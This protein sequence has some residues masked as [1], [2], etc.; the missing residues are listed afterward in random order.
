NR[1]PLVPGSDF[2]RIATGAPRGL[3]NGQHLFMPRVSA[4]WSPF[5][6]NKTSIRTGFG[7][8]YDRPQGNIIYSSLN[9]PPFTQ[10]VQ[11]ENGNLANPSGGTP[12]ALA[13]IATISTI[14]PNL[15]TAYTINYS[16]SVQ[17][18]LGHGYFGEV[19]YVGNKGRNLLWFPDINRPDFALL[20]QA[21]SVPASQRPSTNYLRP[22]KG[23]SSIQERRSEA[24]AN[25][26]G[27]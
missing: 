1:A 25:Y 22:Y 14:N 4:A 17:R 16:V 21:F 9:L 6:S 10:I 11:Y 13:P 24:K 19:A 26:N 5:G 18:E 8:F 12:A 3:Y 15:K 27:L 23:Y 20:S 7:T 2:S